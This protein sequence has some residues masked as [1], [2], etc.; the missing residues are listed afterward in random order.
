[1]PTSTA[2]PKNPT[3]TAMAT[4]AI[5]R[6]IRTSSTC[7]GLVAPRCARV[8]PAMPANRVAVPVATTV[9]VASPSTTKQPA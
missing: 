4:A 3:P 2:S 9:A 5:S 1:M 7:K 8:R 6:E